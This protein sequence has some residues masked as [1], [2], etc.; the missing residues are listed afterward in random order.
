M[1]KLVREKTS[2]FRSLAAASMLCLSITGLGAANA[3]QESTTTAT[4][5]TTKTT[6]SASPELMLFRSSLK[7]DVLAKRRKELDMTQ[8]HRLDWRVEGSGC[9]ACLGRVR[10]R[11]EKLKGIYEVAVAIKEPYGAVVIYDASKL[12]QDQ[13]L[14]AGLKDE[15]IKVFFKDVTDLKITDPPMILIPKF[16][17][18]LKKD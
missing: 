5:T 7:A 10:K 11:I 18:L 9:A 3:T 2:I 15:T 4:T 12:N 1:L 13:I 6:T 14:K 8:L 17:S 16:N